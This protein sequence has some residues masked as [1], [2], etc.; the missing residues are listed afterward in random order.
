[1]PPN[2]TVRVRAIAGDGS[3]AGHT[4]LGNRGNLQGAVANGRRGI[5]QIWLQNRMVGEGASSGSD[6]PNRMLGAGATK[7]HGWRGHNE[8][9]RT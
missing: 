7:S 9:D 8:I 2:R 6:K 1:M 5:D 4:S 3:G